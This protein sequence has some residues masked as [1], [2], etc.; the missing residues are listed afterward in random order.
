MRQAGATGTKPPA[1]SWPGIIPPFRT[2]ALLLALAGC[3]HQTP[4]QE[5][6]TAAQAPS[7][8]GEVT[9]TG[10]AAK[11]RPHSASRDPGVVLRAWADAVEA[12][13][14]ASVRAFWGDHGAGSGLSEAAFAAQW[15]GLQHPKVS[16][17]RGK[18]EGAAGSLYDTAA[19]QIIDGARMISGEVVIRRVNDVDGA[20]AEQLRWHI[21]ST[22]LMP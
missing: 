3:G 19:V 10:S 16:L 5:G 4:T 21:E 6:P 2:A 12:R 9:P 18:S 17:A 20:S 15:A 22:T 14:W 13:D 11:P 8:D 1:V 7:A